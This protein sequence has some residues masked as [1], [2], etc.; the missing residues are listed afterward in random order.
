MA[1]PTQPRVPMVSPGADPALA[2]IEAR[3]APAR[4]RIG[5]LYRVLFNS[6]P[7]ADGW[8]RML[9]AVRKK[10]SVAPKPSIRWS[11]R[12]WRWPTR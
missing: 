12:C 10:T 9:T 5:P 2:A 7:I 6:A 4:G 8:E 1:T 11:R 3:V